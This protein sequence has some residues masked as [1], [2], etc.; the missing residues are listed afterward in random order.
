MKELRNYDSSCVRV[1]YLDLLHATTM[2]VSLF[3]LGL[4]CF[5]YNRKGEDKLIIDRDFKKFKL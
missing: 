4:V 3:F 5:G 2:C 1:C